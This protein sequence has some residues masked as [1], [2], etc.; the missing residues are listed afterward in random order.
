MSADTDCFLAHIR[1]LNRAAFRSGSPR[2]TAFL[3]PGEITL[4]QQEKQKGIV[5]SLWGGWA[6]AE[7][8]MLCVHP[9][10]Y[11]ISPD[12]FPFSCVKVI[13]RRQDA[14][15]HRDLL[16]SVL[17]LG[18]KRELIGDLLIH[19]GAAHLFVCS[20]AVPLVC[21]QLIRVGRVGVHAEESVFDGD[22]TRSFEEISGTV[23]SVRL[24]A[25]VRLA[26]NLSRERA[27]S[28][29][30]SQEVLKNGLPVL[31]A[32]APVQEGDVLS[33]RGF[34]KFRLQSVSGPT[35]KGRL[36]VTLEKYR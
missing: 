36:H 24:D 25:V 31:S 5:Q 13:F 32:S 14:I 19:E 28:L 12:A 18:L 11:G 6:D 16:G 15:T 17:G 3:T 35:K 27:A 1:D 21:E 7:R 9:A 22:Y 10:E 2:F 30:L 33:V 23:A 20:A 26:A 4:A 34:G 29:I 8:K